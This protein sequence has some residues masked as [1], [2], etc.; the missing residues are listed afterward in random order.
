MAKTLVDLRDINFVLWEQNRLGDYLDHPIFKEMTI[1]ELNMSLKQ[2]YDFAVNEIAPLNAKGDVEGVHIVDGQVRIPPSYRPVYDKAIEMGGSMLSTPE[3]Y[4]GEG[5]PTIFEVIVGEI[6]MS[7]CMA[8]TMYLSHM[9][10]FKVFEQVGSEEIKKKYLPV[11]VT[12]E[13]GTTM[14]LS[15]PQA[16]TALGDITTNATQNDDGT[17]NIV[18]N[19]IFITKGDYDFVDNIVHLVLSRTEGAPPG[20]KGL[21][22]FAVPKY[23]LN[24]DGSPGE[25]NNVTCPKVEEKMGLHGSATC[26]LIFGADGPCVG[27]LV[28]KLNKGLPGM[29]VLMNEARILTGVQGLALSSGAYLYALKY[30]KE[31]VQGVELDNMKDVHAP[32]VEIIKHPDIRRML[33]SM[34]SM[35][36]GMRALIYKGQMLVTKSLMAESEEEK[37]ALE[38]QL[39]LLTPVIKAYCSDQ[40]FLVT[41]DAIQ[42]YGGYGFCCDYPVE[43]Y[44]RDI[45]IASLYEGANGMQALD[46]IGRKVLNVQKQMK[47][48][49]DLINSI[50][51]FFEEVERKDTKYKDKIDKA[52]EAIENLDNLTSSIRD[53]ALAGDMQFPVLNATEY[54]EAF[55]HAIVGYLHAEQLLLA[56]E[57]FADLLK[58]K[59][60]DEG[61]RDKL[62]EESDDAAFYAGK[63]H[64]ASFFIDKVLPKVEAISKGIMN[65][66]TDIVDISE[67]SF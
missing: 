28:G 54:L 24:E 1:E 20:M 43:Q 49:N 2:A 60:Y 55:G 48:Y 59:G 29:F 36:E 61:S 50:R 56:E 42:V 45:K 66:G 27:E 34:K 3:E 8:F 47:P 38:D 33:L 6:S 37:E 11:I 62:I 10:A 12:P 46:L 22:L 31:R 16:G 26:E 53:K 40:G 14:C 25:F 30:A 52:R 63:I 35:V 58:E 18:G 7:A 5:L 13:C 17:W 67:S 4:G 39:S 64:S 15:E 32:R 23:R 65:S 9:G 51:S 41:R 19:K 44:M 21:S 57:K